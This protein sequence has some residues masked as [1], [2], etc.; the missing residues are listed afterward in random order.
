[1]SLLGS[2][3]KAITQIGG[4]AVGFATG[5]IGGA[6]AGSGLLRPPASLP[7]APGAMSFGVPDW[8]N[9]GPKIN[10]PFPVTGPGGSQLPGYAPGATNGQCP[11]GYHLN[12][13]ALAPS[14]QHGAVAPRSMCVRNRSINP[15]N[16][17]AVTRS[18]KRLKRARKLVSKLQSF[19]APR[20]LSS[21]R[22]GHKAGCGCVACRRR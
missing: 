8:L 12:K 22:P 20:R 5:G 6:I 14:K 7:A 18:L 4:A 13:H 10:M 17:R 15:L 21:G 11:R 3:G 9:V 16:P 1:M 2:I 19:G